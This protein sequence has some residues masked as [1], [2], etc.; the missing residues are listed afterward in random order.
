MVTEERRPRPGGRSARV[1]AAVRQAVIA[2]LAEVGFA[3][4]SVESVATRAGVHKTTIYRRWPT[5]EDLV[6]DAL[7][8]EL[9]RDVAMPDT[10]SVRTDLRALMHFVVGN[11]TSPVG[12]GLARTLLTE[13]PRSPE[14]RT[15]AQRFWAER[16]GLVGA[17]IRRGVERGELAAGTDPDLLVEA[18]IGPLYLRTLVTL[19]PL[20]SAFADRVLDFAL[21]A[22]KAPEAPVLG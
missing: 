19:A 14:L 13:A 3:K 18:L 4:L 15:L 17:I 6:L 11:L 22:A 21:A 10:G 7:P 12:L 20:D 1:R 8:A 2:E 16:F 9:G 5:R